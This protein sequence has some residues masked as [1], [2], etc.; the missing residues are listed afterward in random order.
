MRV[1]TISSLTQLTQHCYGSFSHTLEPFSQLFEL[2]ITCK[3]CRSKSLCSFSETAN[4]LHHSPRVLMYFPIPQVLPRRHVSIIPVGC[5]ELDS[6]TP[7]GLF[8]LG[9]FPDAVL[10]SQQFPAQTTV[11]LYRWNLWI[12]FNAMPVFHNYLSEDKPTSRLSMVQGDSLQCSD[13]GKVPELTALLPEEPPGARD[14]RY[15]TGDLQHMLPTDS[16]YLLRRGG[17]TKAPGKT[18][19]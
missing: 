7:M 10:R 18:K 9:I 4:D 5:Q 15:S 13:K 6:I 16:W 12:F 14:E 17:K 11:C 2:L 3:F 19:I 8:Q 1:S